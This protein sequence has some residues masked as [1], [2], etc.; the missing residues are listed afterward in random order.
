MTFSF[1]FVSAQYLVEDN[2]ITENSKEFGRADI[3]LDMNNPLEF[4]RLKCANATYAQYIGGEN[5]FKDKLFKNLKAS[6]SNNLYS[7]NGTFDFIFYIDKEG[8]VLTPLYNYLKDYPADL[9]NDFYHKYKGK[10]AFAVKTAS[11][12]LGSLNSGMQLY[13]LKYE[14]PEIFKR[15]AHVL[16][17]PQYL[18]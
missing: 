7:V 11:P 17:L 5:G 6:L 10:E 14:Q 3:S 8:K 9:K 2:D 15:I 18:S 13:R 16:H 4:Y 12:V 1:G